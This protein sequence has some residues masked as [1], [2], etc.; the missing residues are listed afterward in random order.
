MW[1]IYEVCKWAV[2][3]LDQ[4]VTSKLDDVVAG[5]ASGNAWFSSGLTKKAD[6]RLGDTRNV[7]G[8]FSARD[9]SDLKF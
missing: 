5:A 4:M 2:V 1:R 3:V 6:V 8:S 9:G 7:N